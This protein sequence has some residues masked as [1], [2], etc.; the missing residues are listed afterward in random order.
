MQTTCRVSPEMCARDSA[1]CGN[2]KTSV[3]PLQSL[4]TCTGRLIAHHCMQIL[5]SKLPDQSWE[6]HCRECD[7]TGASSLER[8]Q[9]TGPSVRLQ[10]NNV[11]TRCVTL[12]DQLSTNADLSNPILGFPFNATQASLASIRAH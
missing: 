7:I 11:V 4:S 5:V 10:L 12:V 1:C 3:A 2:G 6:V 9:Q 8:L